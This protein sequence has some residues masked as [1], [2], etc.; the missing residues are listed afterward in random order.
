MAILKIN[1]VVVLA[2]NLIKIVSLLQVSMC[3]L[4][5]LQWILTG[6]YKPKFLGNELFHG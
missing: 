3:L 1:L 2:R 4:L 6:I 5:H